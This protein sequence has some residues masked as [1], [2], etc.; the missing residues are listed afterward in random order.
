MA[1]NDYL[2]KGGITSALIRFALP[3]M[4]SMILQI[5]YSAVDLLVVGNF[6]TTADMA[7]VTVSSQVMTTV[8]LSVTGL[9][10][11]LTVLVGQFSGAG[12]SKDVTRAVG[13]SVFF[14][15]L[16]SAGM[17]I[18]FVCLGGAIVTVMRTPP[19]AVGAAKSYLFICS[20]G[21]PFIV[22]YNVVSG[23]FRGL[24]NSR[25][26]LLFVATAC[27]INI[28][29]DLLFIKGFRM[30]ASGAALATVIAQAGSLGASLIFLWKK[31]L[32]FRFERDDFRFRRSYAGRML[33]IGLP[34]S[35][36]EI[37]I[38]ISFLLITAVVNRM[39][40]TASA[41]VGTVEKLI[42]FLMMPTMAISTAVAAMA[43]HNFGARQHVRARK[44]LW[45][46]ILISLGV[47]IPVCA[48]CWLDGGLL[49]SL[50]SRDHEVVYQASLYLKTYAL[51]C[52][53]VAFIFNFNAFFT[54]CSKSLFAMGH[55]L[56]TTFLIRTPFVLI[57]GGMAGVTLLTIGLAAPLSS[58]GS[59]VL[60]VV[61]YIRLIRRLNDGASEAAVI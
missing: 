13:T 12:R 35:L 8:L 28:L 20:L 21:I 16:L 4:L 24:G 5:L 49:T 53:V 41:S 34:I 46:G 3:V 17:T 48:F 47:A 7:G 33:K 19:E 38:N 58:L 36:Q 23:V 22:G 18:L 32:G 15:A 52:I 27:V 55:S 9:T 45:S 61:Y 30:G 2:L 54:S 29:L 11:G 57:A 56:A 1:Q 14:F 43:A 26:P 42:G 37:L 51:D 6:A 60:C 31:G 40:L 59:L 50:F 25:T 39:G 10:T 44:S